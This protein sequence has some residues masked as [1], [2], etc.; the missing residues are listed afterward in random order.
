M[1]IKI[2]CQLNPPFVIDGNQQGYED[3][4]TY[5]AMKTLTF[6]HFPIKDML[7]FAASLETN[8]K[9]SLNN[10][11]IGHA[12]SLLVERGEQVTLPSY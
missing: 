5:Y 11:A 2:L 8:L 6:P 3:M 7:A 4:L 9:T 1:K 12:G 10:I